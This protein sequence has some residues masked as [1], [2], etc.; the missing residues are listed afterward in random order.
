VRRREHKS[1]WD[2]AIVGA[3]PVGTVLAGLLGLRGVRVI[4]VERE[5]DIIQVPR[6][7]H[8][9]HTVLRTL[10]EL[11]CLDEVLAESIPNKG[12][13]MVNGKGE[14]LARL[15]GDIQASSGLPA[16]IHFHQ[17]T[18]EAI[19]RR[20]IEEMPNVELALG[21]EMLGFSDESEHVVLR[22]DSPGEHAEISASFLVGCDGAASPVRKTAGITLEDLG[23]DETWLVVDM[24][25]GTDDL[26]LPANTVALCDPIR[27]GYSIEM[28]HQ[29]HRLEF[30]VMPGENL[31]E[32]QRPDSIGELI[33]QWVDPS[34][35]KIERATV[36]QFHALLARS[37]RVGRVIIAGDAAHQMPP[38]LGQGL[39]TGIRDTENLAWK[40][41]RV[42]DRRSP[43]ALL[44]T[45][46]QER[47]PRSRQLIESAV[48]FG[49]LICETDP[50]AA[51]ERD[52]RML[53]DDRS[54][55]T[56]MGF[57]LG[58]FE[59]GPLVLTGG[60]GLF[61]QPTVSGRRLDDVIGLRFLVLGRTMA[62]LDG[63]RGWWEDEVGALVTTLDDLPDDG[64]E[65][66]RRWLDR[67]SADVVV[68]RPD[69]HVLGTGN[70]LSLLTS[71]LDRSILVSSG[72]V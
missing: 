8:F 12:L 54:P 49:Q 2:V 14:L 51:E 13:D 27:P 64:A 45:Y 35:V 59:P 72:G 55:D 31:N 36:Y 48:G 21:V 1:E 58:G 39:C 30:M 4:A 17:P 20:R 69:R 66:L 24:M 23:F 53:G 33:G 29:R 22:T 16:S 38:F 71:Q 11:G 25:V 19:V 52:C 57:R 26:G 34:L 65:P 67:K 50:E 3:G 43:D 10:Q 70:S 62:E 44:D 41:A 46:E 32:L 63:C 18:L 37:W 61:P 68:V 56:R 60:G 6:A 5:P 40:L 7:G 42:V 47:K 28:D 9:D 15:R